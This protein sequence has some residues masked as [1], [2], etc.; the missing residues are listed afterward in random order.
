M[1]LYSC[2]SLQGYFV[3]NQNSLLVSCFRLT[4]FFGDSY[5]FSAF[6][7]YCVF[8]REMLHECSLLSTAAAKLHHFVFVSTPYLRL[9]C[10]N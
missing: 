7:N 1:Y 4:T 5:L 9:Q 10:S 3:L 2:L 8:V 6:W